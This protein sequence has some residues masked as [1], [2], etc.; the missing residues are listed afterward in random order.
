MKS[1]PSNET[2]R[3]IAAAIALSLPLCAPAETPESTF[4]VSDVKAWKGQPIVRESVRAP[5]YRGIWFALGFKFAYG[6]KYAGGLG[7]YTSSHQP[8]AVYSPEANKTFF[9]YGGTPAGDKRMLTIMVSYFDHATGEVPRPVTLYVDP[10]VDDPH[11]NAALQIDKDGYLWVFK[12]GRAAKRPGLIFRSAKPYSIDA[13][14]CAG[15]QEFT[16]PQVWYTK[17]KGFFLLFT[18]YRFPAPSER[19]EGVERGLYWKTSADGRTWSPDHKL[20]SFEGHYQTSGQCGD[21]IVTFFNW[22]PNSNNDKR[23]NLY[24]AQTAD[25]GKTWT[26]ADGQ[27]LA[28]PLDA[29][30]NGALVFDYRSQGRMMYTS[31]VGFDTGG[32]PI[33]LYLTSC[34]GEPGPAGDPR[35]WVAAHWTGGRWEPHTITQGGHNYDAGAL[36]VAGGEW[37]A[38]LPTLARS[39]RYGLGG[40]M[41]LWTS[42]D[43]GGHWS[44][45]RQITQKSPANHDYARSPIH[46][47]DPFFAFWADGDPFKISR[48][49]L[50]FTTASGDRVWR[51]P[52]EME[53]DFA[54]PEALK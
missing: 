41:A 17:A 54:K 39:L 27:P 38:Y 53:G 18:K 14:E 44:L 3:K 34:A 7:T 47:A 6:D 10:S 21:K 22:H 31:D 37:R 25:W 13:F 42:A 24:Y 33:L 15:V 32:N 2:R 51:L 16:Y 4:A 20:A 26:A 52:Y 40:E 48:S 46:A 8:M 19:R 50:Y 1:F 45:T 5:G 29:P 43:Q 28:L 12:S 23:T 35:D 30:Q 36:A 9:T 11:D 49:H